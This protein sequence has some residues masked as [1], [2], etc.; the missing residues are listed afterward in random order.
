MK[1]MN[2]YV[3]LILVLLFFSL[4]C[5][6]FKPFYPSIFQ[7]SPSRIS[8]YSLQ[9]NGYI[10]SDL[11]IS[12]RELKSTSELYSKGKYSDIHKLFEN[13]SSLNGTI[14]KLFK[15]KYVLAPCISFENKVY[16]VK[17]Y[18]RTTRYYYNIFIDLNTGSI[19]IVHPTVVYTP[20]GSSIKLL[21]TTNRH[22]KDILH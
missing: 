19:V 6:T 1:G 21:L 18:K 22:I 4:A 10:K 8:I 9:H 3:F 16:C 7:T 17:K 20:K 15:N 2:P 12:K 11:E 14:F 13:N 5:M